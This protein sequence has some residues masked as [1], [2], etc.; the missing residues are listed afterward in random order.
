[1]RLAATLGS[2]SLRTWVSRTARERA[3]AVEASLDADDE[4]DRKVEITGFRVADEVRRALSELLD[5]CVGVPLPQHHRD[6]GS[7]LVRQRFASIRGVEP[8]CHVAGG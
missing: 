7:L 6:V 5:E 3:V 4:R 2:K 1:M 8:S